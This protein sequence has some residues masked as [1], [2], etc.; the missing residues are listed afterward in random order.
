MPSRYRM[1]PYDLHCPYFDVEVNTGQLRKA[2][3]IYIDSVEEKNYWISLQLLIFPLKLGR[4]DKV[5]GSIIIHEVKI[6]SY[7]IFLKT[8]KIL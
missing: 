5:I 4:A 2:A 1:L 8:P 7:T 3:A 6:D